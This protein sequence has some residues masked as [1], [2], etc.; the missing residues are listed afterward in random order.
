VD[1]F[2]E[3]RVETSN[4]VAE[5]AFQSANLDVRDNLPWMRAEDWLHLYQLFDRP[6]Q[7]QAL[8]DYLS[9]SP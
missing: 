4:G 9:R 1:L 5:W 7:V 3:V 8:R 6:M 2:A